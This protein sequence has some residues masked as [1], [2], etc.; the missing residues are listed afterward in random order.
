MKTR[1]CFGKQLN[2]I[3][4]FKNPELFNKLLNK[5]MWVHLSS[6]IVKKNP[7]HKC[8]IILPNAM[9][10]MSLD[11]K[12]WFFFIVNICPNVQVNIFIKVP[13]VANYKGVCLHNTSKSHSYYPKIWHL[14]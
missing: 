7:S 4:N 6:W 12:D 14:L 5:R 9:R 3:L 10:V 11:G 13:I 1:D 8:G 2:T